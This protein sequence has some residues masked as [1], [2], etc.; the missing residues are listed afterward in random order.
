MI[1]KSDIKSYI[2]SN[3]N[4]ILLF[5][6]YL[7]IASIEIEYCLKYNSNVINNPLRND[8]HPSLG[9]MFYDTG[10]LIMKDWAN[11][12]FTG[13]I[14]SLVGIII[15]EDSNTST[16]FI[17]I[18]TDIINNNSINKI[19][20]FNNVER[21]NK[22]TSIIKFKERPFTQFDL[23]YWN[24][25]GITID[26]LKVRFV[27]AVQYLWINNMINPVYISTSYKNPKYVYYLGINNNKEIIKAYS[28]FEEKNNKFITN[29]KDFF[30]APNELYTANTLIITKSRKDKLV[31][32]CNLFDDK[33]TISKIINKRQLTHS[34]YPTGLQQKLNKLITK[35]CVTNF[36]SESLRIKADLYY[37]LHKVYNNIIINTDFDKEGIINGFYHN[38]L[39]NIK[40]V[41]LGNN[42][43]TIDNFS[44]KEI[45]G[46]FKAIQYINPNI[47]LFKALFKNYITKNSGIYTDKDLFEYFT[48]NGIK[49]GRKLLIKLIK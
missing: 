5:A 36:S 46:M 43:I 27:Y 11:N 29:S 19:V 41:F 44:D 35:Y 2:L 31:I 34:F 1:V 10:K 21:A 18:C 38:I 28:P 26:Y 8:I 30:E 39:F 45:F 12:S 33:N 6:K 14:F 15:G 4:Q 25:G 40:T 47:T 32:E 48:N 17:N 42:N 13:D 9:F 24:N 3:Y 20:K 37:N 16:G 49:K 22:N 7:D 23:Q